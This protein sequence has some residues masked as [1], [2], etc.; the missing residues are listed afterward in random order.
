MKISKQAFACGGVGVLIGIV[1]AGLYFYYNGYW[2]GVSRQSKCVSK[3]EIVQDQPI[4]SKPTST[5]TN[6][7]IYKQWAYPTSQKVFVEQFNKVDTVGVEYPEYANAD[8]LSSL[9]VGGKNLSTYNEGALNLAVYTREYLIGLERDLA[10]YT[11]VNKNGDFYAAYV[12]HLSDGV[13][14]ASGQ[15]GL[16][17]FDVKGVVLLRVNDKVYEL[18]NPPR[19]FNQTATGAGVYSCTAALKNKEILWTC[20]NGF[21]ANE[22][23]GVGGSMMSETRY[24]LTGQKIATREYTE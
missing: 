1:A 12:T 13:D 19:I 22:T 7:E 23:E 17:R 21:D 15:I 2:G 16:E 4:V 6:I 18:E 24:S 14:V 11:Q 5:V 9:I 8:L 3:S 20:F 10:R